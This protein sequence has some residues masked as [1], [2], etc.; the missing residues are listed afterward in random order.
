VPQKQ[1]GLFEAQRSSQT[2]LFWDWS[3]SYS[4]HQWSRQIFFKLHLWMPFYLWLRIK[5]VIWVQVFLFY[6]IFYDQTLKQRRL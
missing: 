4:A 2:T 6:L 3:F 1:L 5:I